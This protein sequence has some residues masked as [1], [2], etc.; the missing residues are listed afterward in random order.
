MAGI[1]TIPV[2]SVLFMYISIL[3][4]LLLPAGY[5]ATAW[6]LKK[7]SVFSGILGLLGYGISFCTYGVLWCLYVLIGSGGFVTT[8]LPMSYYMVYAVLVGVVSALWM[9]F[10]WKKAGKKRNRPWDSMCFYAGF[11]LANGIRLCFPI[12]EN[13]RLSNIYNQIGIVGIRNTME[14]PKAQLALEQLYQI[15]MKESAYFLI[16]GLEAALLFVLFLA[17]G[18]LLGQI[19]AAEKKRTALLLLLL[20]ACLQ[21][22]T[23]FP[24]QLLRTTNLG[25][26]SKEA[27]LA[28]AACI[29]A[30]AALLRNFKRRTSGHGNSGNAEKN[31]AH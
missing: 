30:G 9:C 18:Y 10:L 26:E 3:L 14:S 4:L 13:I 6:I 27:L 16:S 25:I 8:N 2:Q 7:A 22:M 17:M 1:G 11:A 23:E 20:L 12:I 5:M 29:A 15:S 28:C 21:W 31:A 24:T 19:T